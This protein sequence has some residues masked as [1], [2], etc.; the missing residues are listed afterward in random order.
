MY[1]ERR[2][3]THQLML[4]L[5]L[6]SV[7]KMFAPSLLRPKPSELMLD[8][9]AMSSEMSL[10]KD[11]VNWYDYLFLNSKVNLSQEDKA[12]QK[13]RSRRTL[14]VRTLLAL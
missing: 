5:L 2:I 14:Q 8:L 1:R 10:T 13:K 9:N 4:S 12:W 11:L 6:C 3:T 7:A